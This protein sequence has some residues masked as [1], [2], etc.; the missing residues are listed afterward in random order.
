M[1]AERDASQTTPGT[2][3]LHGICGSLAYREIAFIAAK[4]IVITRVFALVSCNDH[5]AL[6]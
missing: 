2:A 5:C 4:M 3:Q 6:S 1:R